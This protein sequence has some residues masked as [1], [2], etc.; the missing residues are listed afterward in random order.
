MFA[1]QEAILSERAG[2]TVLLGPFRDLLALE[3]LPK[4]AD[5]L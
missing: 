2:A 4:A 5:L 3:A 1:W